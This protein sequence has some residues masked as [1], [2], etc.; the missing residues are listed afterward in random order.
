MLVKVLTAE[1]SKMTG[2]DALLRGL[3]EKA[4]ELRRQAE[5]EAGGGKHVLA[6]ER[7]EGSTRELVRA[8]RS[9]GIFIPG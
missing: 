4:A 8:V 6:I 9:L 3:L 2:M 7:L 5:Q 1:K